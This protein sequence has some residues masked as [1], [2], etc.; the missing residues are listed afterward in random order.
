MIFLKNLKIFFLHFLNF[1]FHQ[2]IK[3]NEKNHISITR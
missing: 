3:N 1:Y 2:G